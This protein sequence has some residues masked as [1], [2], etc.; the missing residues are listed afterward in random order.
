MQTEAKA[1]ILFVTLIIFT[2]VSHKK[3]LLD[4]DGLLIANIVGIIIY[5]LGG[6][7]GFFL[8]VFFFVA[9]EIAT[10]IGK[11]KP[12]HGT[13]TTWNILGNSSAAVFALYFASTIG[14]YGA[15]SAALADTLSSE[16]GLLS[17]KKP[18]LITNWK[19]V[20]H[21]TDGGITLLGTVAALLGASMVATIHLAQFGDWFIFFVIIVTGVCGS[22]ADSILG[23]VFELKHRLD[24]TQ[25]NFLGSAAG[26]VIAVL[27]K[28]L[29]P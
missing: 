25:V 9:G 28:S 13:R 11:K 26:A 3:K 14:F 12:S 18:R 23:A 20:P 4:K 5:L 8:I 15:V 29:K 10:L 16:I 17:D 2:V 22:L 27:L 1:L 19:E 21:G 7:N 24:N 6:L